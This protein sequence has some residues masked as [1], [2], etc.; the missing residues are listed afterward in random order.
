LRHHVVD[1][2]MLA[3][4]AHEFHCAHAE[5]PVS[6]VA[7]D[8]GTRPREIE[9]ARELRPDRLG[10]RHHLIGGLKRA[11]G[12]LAARI[13]NHARAAAYQRVRAVTLTLQMDESH[14]RNEAAYVKRR[15]GRIEAGVTGDGAAGEHAP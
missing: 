15:C 6:I 9:K 3:N 5:Q 10:V 12:S 8:R 14:Y 4:V 7:K 1:G 11:L 13:S 2:E